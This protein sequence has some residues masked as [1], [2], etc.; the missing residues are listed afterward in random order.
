MKSALAF[1]DQML[2]RNAASPHR[3]TACPKNADSVAKVENRTTPKISRKPIFWR[4]RCCIIVGIERLCMQRVCRNRGR[5]HVDDEAGDD[6]GGTRRVLL[7]M[8]I[9]ATPFR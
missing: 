1:F 2:C 9:M 6:T 5:A 7:S 4:L 3:Q 8:I